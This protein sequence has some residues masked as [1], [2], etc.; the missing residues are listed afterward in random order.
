MVNTNSKQKFLIIGAM[1]A[2]FTAICSWIT[3]PLPFTPIPINLATFAVMLTGA[4]I[5]PKYGAYSTITYVILG[6]VGA[7]VF[8]G[9]SGGVGIIAGPT[10]GFIIGYIFCA[11]VVGLLTRKDNFK[12][13]WQL[14][15]SF[16][17]G[18]ITCYVFGLFWFIIS[19]GST[20]TAGFIACIFPFLMGD[21]FKIILCVF[22]Y[23]RLV[24]LI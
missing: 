5:G 12:E 6:A 14:A 2:A 13:K 21:F 1:L 24:K 17:A 15:L 22:L 23:K 3:I 18:T 20:F 16:T 9:F 7:P 8:S 4:L 11:V 19:T 10:G